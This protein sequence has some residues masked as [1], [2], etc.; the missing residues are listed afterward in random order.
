M[1][2]LN[3]VGHVLTPFF[4]KNM[5]N[6]GRETADEKRSII[7]QLKE[8]QGSQRDPPMVRGVQP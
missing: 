7:G 6:G 4:W 1:V 2:L 3:T 8:E 5:S